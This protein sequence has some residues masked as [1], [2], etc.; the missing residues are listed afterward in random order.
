MM[1]VWIIALLP[2][3]MYKSF[4]FTIIGAIIAYIW[5]LSLVTWNHTFACKKIN[6]KIWFDGIST[7]FGY[8]I[9]KTVYTYI[10]NM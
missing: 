3:I 6:K 1:S 8:L 9:P 7:I 4:V 10:L 2:V 5:L